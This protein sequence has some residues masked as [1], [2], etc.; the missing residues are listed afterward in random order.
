MISGRKAYIVT[1][2]GEFD[3]VFEDAETC[4]D[5]CRDLRVQGFDNV[6][7]KVMPWDKQDD[8]IDSL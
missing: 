8:Y 6:T 7:Y 1:V 4:R 3:C 2:D 5:H